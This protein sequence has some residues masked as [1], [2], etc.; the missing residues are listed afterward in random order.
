[1]KGVV[2]ILLLIPL[3]RS[4]SLAELV[5]RLQF[6]PPPGVQ[7]QPVERGASDQ[8]QYVSAYSV[9]PR[10][11]RAAAP[12]VPKTPVRICTGCFSVIGDPTIPQQ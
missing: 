6:T 9:S 8:P 2:L 1:M 3:F 5:D 7:S 11:R 10:L 4:S 12:V